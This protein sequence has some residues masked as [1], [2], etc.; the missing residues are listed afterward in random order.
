MT[1]SDN[2]SIIPLGVGDAFASQFQRANSGFVVLAGPHRLLIDC[3]G[4]IGALMRQASGISG[5]PLTPPLV[6]HML[7]THLHDD[8]SGGILEFAINHAIARNPDTA[9]ERDY[10]AEE[11]AAA[12]K[13]G[14]PT[15][16][17]HAGVLSAVWQQRL[18]VG[19]GQSLTEQGVHVPNSLADFY[20]TNILFPGQRKAIG[21]TGIEVE[22]RATTHHIACAAY[23]VYYKGRSLGVSGDTAFDP[24]LIDWLAEA[25]I[26]FHESTYGPGHTPYAAL[27]DYAL[28]KPSLVERLYL[29]HYPDNFDIAK[30]VLK[31]AEVGKIYRA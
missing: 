2:L 29:Y 25:N 19:L 12:A 11:Q 20:H 6:G 26:M 24:A 4:Y 15:I 30:S 17:S 1:N 16:H 27:R 13:F 14:R 10:T 28:S 7:I 5:V 21:D 3:P 8:H 9:P 22:A 18:K 31:V 23:R